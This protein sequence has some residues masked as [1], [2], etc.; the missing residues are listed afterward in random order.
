LI[1]KLKVRCLVELDEADDLIVPDAIGG[2]LDALLVE[3][4]PVVARLPVRENPK[5]VAEER[6][7]AQ[8]VQL[9]S[10]SAR[11]LQVVLASI[12]DVEV[13]P[14]RPAPRAVGLQLFPRQRDE[15]NIPICEFT[16]RSPGMAA[17]VLE[18]ASP[19]VLDECPE[20]VVRFR[21]DV[22]WIDRLQLG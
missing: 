5:A 20:L 9:V 21:K 19:G 12:P 17:G 7:A 13:Q 16:C 2:R 10:R 18:V 14:E 6:N 15:V 22:G 8:R 1:A 11:G 4:K 3:Q